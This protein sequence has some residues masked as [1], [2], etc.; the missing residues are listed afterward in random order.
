MKNKLNLIPTVLLTFIAAGTTVIYILTVKFPLYKVQY[1]LGMAALVINYAI[2]FKRRS[3]YKYSLMTTLVIGYF[4][5]IHFT[6]FQE[7]SSFSL[8]KLQFKFQGIA[9]LML[10]LTYLLNFNKANNIILAQIRP[11]SIGIEKK[12]EEEISNFKERFRDYN[13]YTLNKILEEKKL[14]PS[15]LEAARQLKE[16]KGLNLS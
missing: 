16:E 3:L 13:L 4:N 9:L 7:T 6:P 10:I 1:F 15:A 8:N 5:F 14:V 2:Y 11:S 12:R